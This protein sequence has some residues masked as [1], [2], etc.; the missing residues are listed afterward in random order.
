M[1]CFIFWRAA[2]RENQMSVRID[3]TWQNNA[4]R[5]IELFRPARL[6]ELSMRRRGPIAAMRSSWMKIA[7][8]RII[9]SSPSAARAGVLARARSEAA[10]SR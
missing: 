9:P 3:K 8:S 4:A 7:P 10:S 2:E 5:E 6:R 1:R